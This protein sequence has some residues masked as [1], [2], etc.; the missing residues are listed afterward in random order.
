MEDIEQVLDSV[1]EANG[2]LKE[3]IK[4]GDLEMIGKDLTTLE[5]LLDQ[6]ETLREQEIKEKN[7]GKKNEPTK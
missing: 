5:K 4:S 2:N 7:G 1:I 3:S 6:L